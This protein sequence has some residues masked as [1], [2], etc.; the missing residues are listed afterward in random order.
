MTEMAHSC[1]KI[2][3]CNFKT[4]ILR[5]LDYHEMY[6]KLCCCWNYN[7]GCRVTESLWNLGNN[8]RGECKFVKCEFC[9]FV[10]TSGEVGSHVLICDH[11]MVLCEICGE[12]ATA[13]MLVSHMKQCG[14]AKI[15]CF[16]CGE[17]FG[18][19][20]DV[21]KWLDHYY[22][23]LPLGVKAFDKFVSQYGKKLVRKLLVKGF[24]S[25]NGGITF[26]GW[27][28]PF[29]ENPELDY[30]LAVKDR[31]VLHALKLLDR[32]LVQKSHMTLMI[33]EGFDK[34]FFAEKTDSDGVSC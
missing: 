21:S 20:G 18:M 11:R 34:C 27:I 30:F 26:C 4:D 16:F 3:G 14:E 2:P 28:D 8:H 5:E 22:D 23:C 24:E 7:N 13:I 32:E 25:T 9:E 29:T 12:G 15:D 19:R 31:K 17:F 6:C 10:G 1:N 33:R